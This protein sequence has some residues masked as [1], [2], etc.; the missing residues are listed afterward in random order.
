MSQNRN[1]Y[2]FSY[3]EHEGRPIELG[4]RVK[5]CFKKE[6]EGLADTPTKSINGNLKNGIN[7]SSRQN[8]NKKVLDEG[9][10]QTFYFANLSFFSGKIPA[11]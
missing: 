4:G 7:D 8:L 11:F 6:K 2:H 9:Q 1:W 5:G 10:G 3:R